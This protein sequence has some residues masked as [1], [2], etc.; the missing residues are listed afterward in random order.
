[1]NLKRCLVCGAPLIGRTDKKFCSDQCRSIE[2][3]KIKSQSERPIL[4]LNKT[5]RKNRSILKSL[6]PVGMTTVRKDI[7]DSMGFD[8]GVFSSLFVNRNKQVYYFSYDYGF[9]PLIVKGVKKALI[10]TK[11]HYMNS[12][13]PWKYVKSS[14]SMT[15][16]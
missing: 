3:N 2:N 16:Q 6:S 5:L 4:E 13:N 1:M 7:L 11:Q 12:W 14:D 9:T 8:T 15:P 10:V